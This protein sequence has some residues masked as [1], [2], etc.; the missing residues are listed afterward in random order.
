MGLQQ[1]GGVNWRGAV[2]VS[3][4]HLDVYKRQG[5]TL[6]KLAGGIIDTA[7][8]MAAKSNLRNANP[9]ILAVSTNDALGASARNIGQLMNARNVY[10]VPMAQ[11]DPNGKP[12][13]VVAHFERIGETLA[14][15]F[16]G[17]QLQPVY[18]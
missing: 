10:F 5:N 17:R 1:S 8:V 14:E 4:T 15:A 11:D 13:S 2:P 18:D 6:G 3:Y 12:A 16:K 7:P 9:L